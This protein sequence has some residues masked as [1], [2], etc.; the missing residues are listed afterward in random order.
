MSTP[1][2]QRPQFD[3]KRLQT[4]SPEDPLRVLFSACLLGHATGWE[5]TAY[6]T[7]LAVQLARLEGVRALSFCPEDYSLGTPRPL[8]TL[9][10]GNGWDVLAGQARVL[11]R[12]QRDVTE[13]LLKGA[14]AMLSYAQK[15]QV[16]LAVLLDISDSCG[17]HV[18]Y[19][20]PPEERRYQ[21]GPGVAAALLLQAGIPVMAQRDEASLQRLLAQLNPAFVPDPSAIDYPQSALY[22][23]YIEGGYSGVKL[24]D[25]ERENPDWD[26]KD[27]K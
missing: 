11:E 13:A 7:P 16:E 5:G 14:Q 10:E 17:S 26:K 8:T 25:F 3:W 2:E 20:G 1:L 4:V 24:A 21:A 22:R 6:T 15:A 18:I 23:A 12:T 9:Y 19:L 27:E